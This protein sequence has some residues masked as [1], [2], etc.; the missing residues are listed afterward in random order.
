MLVFF[1]SNQAHNGWNKN[2]KQFFP[3]IALRVVPNSWGWRI[4]RATLR[5]FSVEWAH[6]L[7]VLVLIVFHHHRSK[8]LWKMFQLNAL[9]DVSKYYV[10]KSSDFRRLFHAYRIL[11]LFCVTTCFTTH[12]LCISFWSYGWLLALFS[13]LCEHVHTNGEAH[14]DI[15][16]S[17][18]NT[19]SH[20]TGHLP[21]HFSLQVS[22]QK[23]IIWLRDV[24][25]KTAAL[26]FFLYRIFFSC[27]S[28]WNFALRDNLF[29]RF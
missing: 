9:K 28:W 10:D 3:E 16:Y 18:V 27:L 23:F 19:M 1:V 7:C 20:G 2:R 24:G 4:V 13:P 29:D 6:H 8:R 11:F 14:S 15:E 17:R 12:L 21:F 5:I 25:F 26:S 22:Q